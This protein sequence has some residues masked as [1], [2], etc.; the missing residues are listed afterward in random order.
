MWHDNPGMSR[1]EGLTIDSVSVTGF[2]SGGI[3]SYRSGKTT[4]FI[5]NVKV[6]NSVTYNNPGYPGLTKPSGASCLF[7]FPFQVWRGCPPNPPMVHNALWAAAVGD[8]PDHAP[9]HMF[10]SLDP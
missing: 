6:L 4:P 7:V 8:S 3:S 5:Q 2:S 1:I 10:A 9:R